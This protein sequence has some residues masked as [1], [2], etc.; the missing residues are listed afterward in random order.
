MLFVYDL[1]VVNAFSEI[2]RWCIFGGS[3]FNILITFLEATKN[4]GKISEI[5]RSVRFMMGLSYRKY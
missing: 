1:K 4:R 5:R 2:R 3:I